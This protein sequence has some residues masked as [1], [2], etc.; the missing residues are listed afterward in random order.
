MLFMFS[1]SCVMLVQSAGISSSDVPNVITKTTQFGVPAAFLE[2]DAHQLIKVGGIYSFTGKSPISFTGLSVGWSVNDP[3][4]DPRSFVV[5]IRTRKGDI[6]WTEWV[7]FP[8]NIGP[9]ESPSGLFWSHLYTPSDFSV[10]VYFEIRIQPPAGMPLT[11][12]RVTVTDNSA[13]PETTNPRESLRGLGDIT[14]LGVPAEPAI[15]PRVDWLGAEH[16]WNVSQITISHAIVHHTNH[17]NI[18]RNLNQSKQL[19]RDIRLNDHMLSQGKDDI[20]Y[21]FVIDREGRIFQGRHN[22][23]HSTT[24]VWGAHA[25]FSNRYSVGIALMGQFQPGEPIPVGHPSAASLRSLERLLAWRFHQRTLNPLGQAN[26]NTF[27][28]IRNIHRIAGHRDVGARGGWTACPGDNLQV[29]LPTIRT[30]VRNLIPPRLHVS[31]ASVVGSLAPGVGWTTVGTVNVTNPGG[32]TLNW[33]ATSNRAWLSV[34]PSSGTTTT[35][36]DSVSVRA[37]AAGLLPGTYTG[38]ITFTGASPATGTPA[39]IN[40]TLTVTTAAPVV[41]PVTAGDT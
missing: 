1:M 31:P 14:S 38:T 29:L 41:F 21:N 6:P 4:A 22:P 17:P 16:P 3:T 15:I 2:W 25:F 28:G 10:H 39:T 9:G 30:N 34:T 27:W 18:P 35:E 26:I 23:W 12:V 11:F 32:G 5:S 7:H 8:G 24:D 33:S 20:G 19:M 13:V 37:T 40:V 36:T